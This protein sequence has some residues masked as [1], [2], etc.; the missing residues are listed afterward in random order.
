M[1]KDAN[2]NLICVYFFDVSI[3]FAF[4]VFS[5]KQITHVINFLA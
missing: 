5:C 2:L 1:E 3:T 4:S